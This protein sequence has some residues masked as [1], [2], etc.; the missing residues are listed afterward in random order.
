MSV[1]TSCEDISGY[2]NQ[3]KV[4]DIDEIL[5]YFGVPQILTYIQ[6]T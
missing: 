2:H 5:G 3:N 1:L 6:I 4:L